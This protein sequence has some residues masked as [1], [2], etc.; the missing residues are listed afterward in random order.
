M[1]CFRRVFRRYLAKNDALNNYFLLHK[2]EN[3]NF[4]KFL[5]HFTIVDSNKTDEP[6][7]QPKIYKSESVF[8]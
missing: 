3:D 1:L 6:I 8:S 4:S 7:L 5:Q 2:N